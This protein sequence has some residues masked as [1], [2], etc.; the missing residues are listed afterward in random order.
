MKFTIKDSFLYSLINTLDIK[1]FRRP[2]PTPFTSHVRDPTFHLRLFHGVFVVVGFDVLWT[3]VW[4]HWSRPLTS[5]YMSKSW[6]FSNTRTAVFPHG[7]QWKNISWGGNLPLGNA[8][9]EYSESCLG[10]IR[11]LNGNN[12]LRNFGPLF[13]SEKEAYPSINE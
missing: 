2:F 3:K 8:T 13:M 4:R 9:W 5:S 11:V 10:I 6:G 1:R 7:K 12:T